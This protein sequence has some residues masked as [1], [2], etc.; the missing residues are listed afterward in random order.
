MKYSEEKFDEISKEIERVE[1]S[2]LAPKG[3]EERTILVVGGA[4][5]IGSVM[6]QGLCQ[7]R[8]LVSPF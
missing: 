1:S 6:I 3:L 4:G 2:I 7:R 5:Y 8:L